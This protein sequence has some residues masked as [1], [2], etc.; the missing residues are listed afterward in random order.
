M[1]CDIGE[2]QAGMLTRYLYENAVAPEQV[3]DVLHDL[4]GSAVG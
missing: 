3:P 2:E 1:L 4:C